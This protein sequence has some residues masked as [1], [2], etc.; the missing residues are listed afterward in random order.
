MSSRG[1]SFHFAITC[2]RPRAAHDG[3]AVP[4]IAVG[5]STK[6]SILATPTATHLSYAQP[7]ERGLWQGP[8]T[9][10]AAGGCLK[11]RWHVGPATGCIALADRCE[12]A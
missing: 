3:A 1:P 5:S 9:F 8:H 4:N 6:F 12:A 11:P 10:V 2:A 7:A